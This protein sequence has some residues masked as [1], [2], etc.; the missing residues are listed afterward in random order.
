MILYS[1]WYILILVKYIHSMRSHGPLY[2]TCFKTTTLPTAS[3]FWLGIIQVSRLRTSALN[4]ARKSGSL[5]P[6]AVAPVTRTHVIQKQFK[7]F[8]YPVIPEKTQEFYVS[9]MIML[10]DFCCNWPFSKLG[11]EHES[12]WRNLKDHHELYLTQIPKVR[13]SFEVIVV[14]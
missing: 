3:P 7:D 5:V 12:T 6:L 4:R 10:V 2:C 14:S 13:C 8:C 9:C 1:S 11:N